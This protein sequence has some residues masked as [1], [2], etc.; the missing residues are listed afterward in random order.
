MPWQMMQKSALGS[1]GALE[2]SNNASA[3][4]NL[5]KGNDGAVLYQDVP[6]MTNEQIIEALAL[7]VRCSIKSVALD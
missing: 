6:D 4:V 5:C 1:A 7:P 2:I 3:N